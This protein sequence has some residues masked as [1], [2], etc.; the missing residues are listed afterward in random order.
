MAQ[1]TAKYVIDSE[2]A[3]AK[4]LDRKKQQKGLRPGPRRL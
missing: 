2:H 4:A 3:K 1:Q